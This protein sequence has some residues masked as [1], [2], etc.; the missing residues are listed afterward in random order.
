MIFDT[1]QQGQSMFLWLTFGIAL[2]LGAVVNKTNFCTMGAVSDWVNMGDTGRMRSWLLAIAVALLGVVVLEYFGKVNPDASFPPYRG[3]QFIW[4]ENLLG[5]LMF[6]IGM[7]LASGCGNKSLIRIGGGNLKSI[8]VVLIIAVIAYYMTNPFPGSDKTLFSVLFNGWLR[9][10][11]I[12][13]GGHQ[14]LGTLLAGAQNAVMARLII[15]AIL[16][17]ALLAYI[18]KSA[19]FRTNRDLIIGGLVVGLAVLGAWYVTSNISVQVDGSRHTLLDYGQQWD[20]L[21][22]SDAGKPAD[23]RPLSPQSFTFINPM[24]Q[25]WGYTASGFNKGL[26]TFGVMALLGVVAGSFLWSL[27]SRSF[28]IE[29]FASFKDFVTHVIGAALMGFGGVLALGCTIGQGITGVSTL[30]L[31]SFIA[32]FAIVAGSAITMKVQ[33][34]IM[35]REA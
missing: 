27:V 14:D 7:T 2:I 32:F 12:N 8:V 9:P 29:W 16:G 5:G 35:M 18:F 31:G 33:Y 3:A 19:D 25:M 21:A 34:M 22:D 15:G 17:L 20:F 23:V 11:A 26:L 1:F 30:A 28:R 24:G 6:G 4:A 13:L 10:L